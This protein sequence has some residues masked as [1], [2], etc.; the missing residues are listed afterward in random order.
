MTLHLFII[1]HTYR[2]N[3]NLENTHALL[4]LPLKKKKKMLAACIQLI[5]PGLDS[6]SLQLPLKCSHLGGRMQRLFSSTEQFLLHEFETAR[7]I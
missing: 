6:A 4:D 1:I 5:G 3:A 2:S 7:G